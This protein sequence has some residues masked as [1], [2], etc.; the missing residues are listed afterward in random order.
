MRRHRTIAAAL[1]LALASAAPADDDVQFEVQGKDKVLGTIRPADE[2]ESILCNLVKGT[3]LKASVKSTQKTG[4]VPTLEVTLDDLPVAGA[5]VTVK[6]RGATLAPFV[7]DATGTY[8]VAVRGDSVL[9]GDYQFAVSWAAQKAFSATGTSA[10][11]T[12]FPFAAPAGSAVTVTLAAGPGSSFVPHLLALEGPSM[13]SIALPGGGKAGPVGLASRGDWNV[14][15]RSDAA[16]GAYKISVKVAAPKPPKHS[17]DIRD[18]ALGGAFNGGSS[19]YGAVLD[20]GTGGDVGVTDPGSPIAGSSVSVP[21]D[22]LGQS[23]SIFV[24]ESQP[25]VPPGGDHPAG[26]AVEFGPSG[27]QFD[28]AHPATVTIPYD[29]NQFPVDTSSLVVYVKDANGDV[30]AVPGPYTFG[31][32]TVTFT[33]SHFSTF[34][35]ATS[36]TRGAPEG[37]Y[38]A[39][40]VGGY[41]QMGFGGLVSVTTGIVDLRNGTFSNYLNSADFLFGPPNVDNVTGYAYVTGGGDGSSGTTFV[42]ADNAIQLRDPSGQPVGTI[43]RGR[44]DDALVIDQ[45][46]GLFQRTLALFRRPDGNPTLNAL[47]GRW[48]AFVW[49]YRAEPSAAGDT[50]RAYRCIANTGTA[51]ITGTGGV[52]FQFAGAVE[53]STR[54]PGG[55]WD[56]KKTG[57]SKVTG[58][59]QIDPDYIPLLRL[60]TGSDVPPIAFDPVL[61]GDVLLASTSDTDLGTGPSDA[62]VGLIILVRQSANASASD[63][64]GQ[65]FE[66]SGGLDFFEGTTPNDQ[67]G[68][69]WRAQEA[70]SQLRTDRSYTTNGVLY[71]S[72]YPS[73]A[74][75]PTATS[76]PLTESAPTTWSLSSDGR[77]GLSRLGVTG[78][79]IPGGDVGFFLLRGGSAMLVGFA[80]RGSESGR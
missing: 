17:I 31:A 38:V 25:Y 2:R 53:R 45:K 63:V 9:D 78:A 5:I 12:L 26:P 23:T 24:A 73:G 74:F 72:G 75:D 58:N 69:S 29:P 43:R 65:L 30:T 50:D 27:T 48:H 44:R 57:A 16:D 7:A 47:A 51:T 40:G 32:G 61:D 35:A 33:T 3:T 28:P 62:Q 4:P 70:S 76:T 22:S 13:A 18:S 15:F 55:L 67:L 71:L 34:M 6:G 39:L 59:L 49:E 79:A 8:K 68:I 19:V 52:T 80:I 46:P 66:H 60:D 10:G 56:T 36:G 20:P 11:E 42:I 37:V 41:P 54:F 14:R 77:F 64:A 1:L 21:P